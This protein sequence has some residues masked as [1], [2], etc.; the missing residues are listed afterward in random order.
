MNTTEPSDEWSYKVSFW[1]TEVYEGKR[2][3][4]P[5]CGGPWMARE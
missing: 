3:T 2:K 5:T 4:V 1:K